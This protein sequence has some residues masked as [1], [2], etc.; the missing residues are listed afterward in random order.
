MDVDVQRLIGAV[1][2][3]VNRFEKDGKPAVAVVMS[4]TY[5]TDVD[6]LW[7]ALTDQER[8]PRWFA[9]VSG[10]LKLGGRYQVQG[11]AGGTI[12][13]CEAPDGGRGRFAA[14]WEFGPAVSWIDVVVAS[15]G[16]QARLTL[17]HI[18][19][20][21]GEHWDKYGPGAVGI[22]WDLGLLGL[23]TYFG[24]APADQQVSPPEATAWMSSDNAKAF[25]RSS[26]E[27]W[28]DADARGGLDAPTAAR[29]AKETIA[30]YTGGPAP[31]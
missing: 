31:E 18:R 23:D 12:T 3:S 5:D 11:N 6:D 17:Q 10:E 28:R 9:P 22:G 16:D 19:Y 1:T 26:G 24:A 4:R 20:E 14:T 8:L 13:E 25:I 7:D 15:E 21:E 27:D 2:R 29:R 30:F